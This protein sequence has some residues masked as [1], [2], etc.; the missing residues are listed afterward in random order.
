MIKT[1]TK[2]NFKQEVENSANPVLIDLWAPWCVYCR[3]ISPALDR[4]SEKLGDKVTIGK[5]NIDDEP[6]LADLLDASTIPTLYVYKNGS[7]G[8]KL[9]AP[10]SQAQIE[11]FLQENGAL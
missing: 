1:I 8:E 3:R 2:D 10:G 6:E 5:I 7:H 11:T 4:L 9:V